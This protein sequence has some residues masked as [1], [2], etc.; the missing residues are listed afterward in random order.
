MN[1]K[2]IRL[3][4]NQSKKVI[5][6]NIIHA[7]KEWS[8][9]Y[10]CI[11][12]FPSAIELIE[13]NLI[14]EEDSD[15]MRDS[16][17]SNIAKHVIRAGD[18][19][20]FSIIA[21]N[22]DSDYREIYQGVLD[23]KYKKYT[24]AFTGLAKLDEDDYEFES[25]IVELIIDIL[26]KSIHLFPID[27]LMKGLSSNSL[28]SQVFKNF[29]DLIFEKLNLANKKESIKYFKKY[30]TKDEKKSYINDYSALAFAKDNN[31]KKAIKYAAKACDLR[32]LG[33]LK[34]IAKIFKQN[35]ETI[36][37]IDVATLA[38]EKAKQI[39][40][41]YYSQSMGSTA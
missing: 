30:A 21:K 5:E 31:Y 15:Y 27:L 3:L 20:T 38:V 10:L 33:L 40:W 35:N 17:Y 11:K 23:L 14:L 19:N 8:D 29:A 26:P 1:N 9:A 25:Y 6:I 13:I 16:H 41:G 18:R 4:E 36:I 22:I 37:A 32:E 28:K 24:D 39:D 7:L 12:D 34:D 2:L